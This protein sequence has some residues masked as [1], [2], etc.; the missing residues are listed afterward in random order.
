MVNSKRIF[1]EEVPDDLFLQLLKVVG[2]QHI[3]DYRFISKLTFT[4]SV[5]EKMDELLILLQPYYLPHKQYLLQRE[6][7]ASR[8]IHII[9][10]VLRQKDIKLEMYPKGKTTLYRIKPTGFSSTNSFTLSFD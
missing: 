9:R 5:C 1:R 4:P 7:N 8:Y 6:M 10:Q 3:Q 2:I